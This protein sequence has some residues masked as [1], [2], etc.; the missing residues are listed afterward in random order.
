MS[1]VEFIVWIVA[2]FV[3]IGIILEIFILKNKR[4]KKG[5][6][7]MR[8]NKVWVVWESE[9]SPMGYTKYKLKAQREANR[10]EEGF[11]LQ[12][13]SFDKTNERGKSTNFAKEN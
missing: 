11:C 8:T 3:F 6:D 2:W 7:N 4:K 5:N 12:I 1:W 10:Y 13:D 9:G